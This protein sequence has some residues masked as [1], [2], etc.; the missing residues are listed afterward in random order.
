MSKSEHKDCSRC[1]R[2]NGESFWCYRRRYIF[3]I[4]MARKFAASGH[5]KIE[6]EPDDVKY[7]VGRCQINE[8]HLPHVDETIPGIVAHVFYPDEDGNIVHGHR[9]IDGHHRAARCLQL[10]IPFYVYV[11]S[12][13]ESTR[14]LMKSPK[15]AR[16][17]FVDGEIQPRSEKPGGSKGR[18]AKAGK[19]ARKGR[20]RTQLA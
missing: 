7:S 13:D 6:L 14:T 10:G 12:E 5:E 1:T 3:D 8:G 11:L 4:D 19:K 16:P 20:R 15:G 17:R 9:L 18:K 2:G